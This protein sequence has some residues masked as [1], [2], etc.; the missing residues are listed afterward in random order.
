MDDIPNNFLKYGGDYV[1]EVLTLM[2]N[3]LLEREE[4]LSMVTL[5]YKLQT[6]NY[7]D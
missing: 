1:V 2:F 5:V 6:S 7:A 3:W 4:F